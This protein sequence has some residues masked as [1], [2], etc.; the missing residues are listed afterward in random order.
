MSRL[1]SET[2]SLLL[3]ETNGR[4]VELY[5]GSVGGELGEPIA[6]NWEPYVCLL[7]RYF[8]TDFI[9]ARRIRVVGVPSDSLDIENAWRHGLE[10]ALQW[11]CADV[12][13]YTEK[14]RKCLA[15][16]DEYSA[17]YDSHR[18]DPVGRPM[19]RYFSAGGHFV[20][21]VVGDRLFD[22]TVPFEIVKESGIVARDTQ[23]WFAVFDIAKDIFL[24]TKGLCAASAKAFEANGA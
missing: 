3:R 18:A 23:E 10:V 20:D 11:R 12:D 17:A 6:Q 4:F 13:S 5:M 19:D 22:R 2:L 1:F 16:V 24:M 14:L 15:A 9:R 21:L 8:Y 7:V